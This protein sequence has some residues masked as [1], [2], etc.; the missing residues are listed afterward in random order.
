M[1][2]PV[3]D[4]SALL[5]LLL[6]EPGAEQVEAVL[7]AACISSVNLAE[8]LA[9]MTDWGI[10]LENAQNTIRGLGI[11]I[12][13]F[14]ADQA[15]HSAALRKHTRQAGLSLGD[16]ACLALALQR[17]APAMTTDKAWLRLDSA[18]LPE[19]ICIRGMS[20]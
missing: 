19:I 8:A 12:V 7:P 1:N 5:A 17:K 16:R 20:S 13:D 6:R 11:E 4:C 9:K 3:L 2:D 10:T 14:D 18:D 15:A